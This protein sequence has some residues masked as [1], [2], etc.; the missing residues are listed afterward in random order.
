MC[1]ISHNVIN[2]HTY[3][4]KGGQIVNG[5]SEMLSYLRKREN[6]SQRELAKKL[7]VSASTIGMYESGKR[8][9][10]REQEEEIADFL[11]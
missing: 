11:T 4:D 9:P 6:L 5:F 10:S 8:Y 3:C 1:K 2:K 7:H